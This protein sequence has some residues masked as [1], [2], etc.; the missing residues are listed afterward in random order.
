MYTDAT[1]NPIE[2]TAPYTAADG[3]NYQ[4]NYPKAEIAGLFPVTL[5]P[6]P[7]DHSLV[8][9][10]FTIDA[11]HAQVGNAFSFCFKPDGTFLYVTNGSDDKVYQYA[12]SA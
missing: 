10:G 2:N 9:T 7:I 12:V 4:S 11:A 3:T 1:L 5:T 6:R 8:V